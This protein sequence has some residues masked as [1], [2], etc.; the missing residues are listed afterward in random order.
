MGC[1][2]SC[3]T[4]QH[5]ATTEMFLS[6]KLKEIKAGEYSMCLITK[7]RLVN[8]G[9][10]DDPGKEEAE[11]EIDITFSD[12]EL[13]LGF[14]VSVSLY[15]RDDRDYYVP[16]GKSIIRIKKDNPDELVGHVGYAYIPPNHPKKWSKTF[17]RVWDFGDQ[18]DG[19]EEY[20]ALVHVVP[21][22]CRDM[23]WTNQINA[24]LG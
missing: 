14:D 2:N 20:Q 16:A 21:R 7:A 22:I 13:N 9:R 10:A 1:E 8:V 24:N 4:P 17:K 15:E 23:R 3:R 18:E 19:D 5:S 12:E 6:N 11:V